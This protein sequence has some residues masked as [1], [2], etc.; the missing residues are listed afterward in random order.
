VLRRAFCALALAS[1]LSLPALAAGQQLTVFA[2]ASLKEVL[3]KLA[4]SFEARTSAK[5]Q[6][7]LAGSQ[8]L[9][10]QLENGARADLFLSADLKHAEALQKDGLLGKVRV[11][12]VNEPVICV[13]KGN[14]GGLR[15]LA[16]LPKAGRI[17]VGVP[18]VPIGAYTVQLLERAGQGPLGAG[19]KAAVEAR[20]AS[21]ELNVRQVLAKV[22]LGEADAGIVYRTDVNAMASKVDPIAL[23]EELKI[24]ARYPAG[25]LL[26]A[27][28][29]KLAAAFLEAL[30]GDEGQ[31][32][33]R[34]AGFGPGEPAAP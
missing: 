30:F 15:T 29:P 19:F 26:K 12:A 14:P 18:E 16:D 22:A 25:A 13:P 4:A 21:R 31:R 17:V 23:P 7:Q 6:L 33:L 34:E 20:I 24:V 32:L 27:P 2:A 9:R 3:Q 5:V 1:T 10:T 8:E 28:E 11:F